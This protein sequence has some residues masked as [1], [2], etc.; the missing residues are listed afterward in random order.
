M[1]RVTVQLV[2]VFELKLAGLQ[3]SEE[4]SAVVPKPI[5]ALAEPEPA[6]AVS[7]AV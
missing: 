6:L 3:E 2:E 4:T 1:V 5:T 7:V